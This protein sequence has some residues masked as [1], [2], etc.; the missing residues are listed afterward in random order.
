V[1]KQG[2]GKKG[3]WRMGVKGDEKVK[4]KLY[5]ASDLAVLFLKSIY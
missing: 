3:K 1:R 5:P 2:D 4:I